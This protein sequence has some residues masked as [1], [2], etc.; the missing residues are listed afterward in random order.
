LPLVLTTARGGPTTLLGTGG[1]AEL[2][3][4]ARRWRWKEGVEMA[5]ESKGAEDPEQVRELG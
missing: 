1:R 4:R 2:L 5:Q 3:K